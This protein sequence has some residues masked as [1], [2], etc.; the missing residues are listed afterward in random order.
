M[1]SS[2]AAPLERRLGAISGVTEIT[3]TSSLG[4]ATIALQFDLS[5]K[6]D[7]AAQDVQAAINA[8]AA[9]LPSDMPTLPSIRKVN[10]NAAPVMVIVLTSKTLPSNVLFDAADTVIVQRLSQ[11]NG[12]A[13]VVVSGADQPAVRVEVDPAAISAAGITL[14]EIRT[15]ISNGAA[16]SPI[17][18][19]DGPRQTEVLS[20]NSQF[21]DASEYKSLTLRAANGT[22]IRLTDIAKVTDGTRNIHA[23]GTY[24]G[25]PAITLTI[26]K[27]GSANVVETIDHVR[28]ILPDIKRLIPADIDMQ[29]MSDRTTTIRASIT[30]MQR[31][32]VVSVVLV[33]GVVL[34][35]LG[36]FVPML[37][38]GITIPLAFA[39]TFAG[40]WVAGFSI[41]NL[42]LM[43][44]AISVGFVVDDAIVV[45]E[46]IVHRLEEGQ[47]AL[48]AAIEGAGQIAFT[49]ITI[50]LSLVAAFLPLLFM[51]GI[52]GKFFQEFSW[53]VTYA[54]AISTV[55]ALT[56]TPMLCGRF[57]KTE[58]TGVERRGLV[59]RGL[60]AVIR[61]YTRTLGAA[62]DH[63]WLMLIVFGATVYLTTLL[64]LNLPKGYFPQDDSG[65]LFGS[66]QASADI[67]FEAM[68][69]LQQE[70]ADIVRADP[71]VDH[72]SSFI[73]TSGWIQS[74]N[75]G[76]LLVSLKPSNS[77]SCRRSR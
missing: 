35:F 38:A 73:G 4:S 57:L 12:V 43:A 71:A 40:M 13:E 44:L 65:L 11:V 27:S 26:T 22:I 2:V 62:L 58:K 63:V 17:G 5:R 74:A 56:V 33:M 25:V 34:F 9:D 66:T 50:S 54:I 46:N 53:T 51:G 76:R 8:A 23:A 16:L 30:D 61:L 6:V 48:H 19:L 21:K 75:N 36:R 68:R 18:N 55:V 72:V 10:P 64:F 29:I 60:D 39:G 28:A 20:V 67:S 47:S 59:T 77:A 32:L 1:A 70:A 41:D 45:I 42:S 31:T 14:E 7:K 24:D 52:V 37:A 69:K 15:A 49:V 3:S